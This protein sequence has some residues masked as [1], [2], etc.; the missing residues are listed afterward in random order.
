MPERG[1]RLAEESNTFAEEFIPGQSKS[2]PV[3][4]QEGK[5]YDQFITFTPEE[6]ITL[7]LSLQ[8]FVKACFDN[9][10]RIV[11]LIDE[12]ANY[13]ELKNI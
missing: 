3:F 9:E 2:E 6:V 4:E 5:S 1:Y 10:L 13:D 12:A 11:T 8:N 7:H